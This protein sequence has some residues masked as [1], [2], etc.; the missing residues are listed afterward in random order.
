ML[1]AIKPKDFNRNY[2][3]LSEKTK[4]NIIDD[5]YFHRLYYSDEYG[6]VKGFFLDFNLRNVHVERYFNKLKCNF[7]KNENSKIIGFIK[8]IE[9]IVLDI[10]PYKENKTPVYR[11]SEQ[12]DNNFIKIFQSDNYKNYKNENINLLLK[13]SGV[14]SNEKQYGITF[15]LFFIRQ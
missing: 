9:Q 12:L 3:M 5:G 8:I 2:L 10:L 11:L 14:W 7:N 6:T 15:R 1:I 13:I 4:N